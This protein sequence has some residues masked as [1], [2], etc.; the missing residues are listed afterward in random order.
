LRDPD[1]TLR[2][3]RSLQSIAASYSGACTCRHAYENNCAHF[4]SNA[5]IAA[6]FTELSKSNDNIHARCTQQRPIR[7]RDMK[8]WFHS[9]ASTSSRKLVRNTGWWAVFQLD[10]AAYWGGHVCIVDTGEWR[11]YGTGFYPN[12]EQYAFKW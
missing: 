11:H 1:A 10:E 5:I 8:D 6:G 4:L 2:S 12:W 9:I 3:V 7:A